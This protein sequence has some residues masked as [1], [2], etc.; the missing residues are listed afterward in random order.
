MA[1][2][3]GALE[4]EFIKITTFI[5]STTTGSIVASVKKRGSRSEIWPSVL[6]NHFCLVFNNKLS[7]LILLTIDSSHILI[8]VCC[9]QPLAVSEPCMPRKCLSHNALTIMER[10]LSFTFLPTSLFNNAVAIHLLLGAVFTCNNQSRLSPVLFPSKWGSFTSYLFPS[11]LF[12]VSSIR[13]N[14][15]AS[16]SSEKRCYHKI[17]PGVK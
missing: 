16:I 5:S 14:F 17:L 3:S 1:A 4:S 10:A 13:N 12:S 7:A 6:V 9:K 2:Y 11:V 8:R 15:F